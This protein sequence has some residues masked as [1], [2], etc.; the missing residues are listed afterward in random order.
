MTV[1]DLLLTR[2]DDDRPALRW[3][4]SGTIRELSWREYVGAA[5]RLA[6]CLESRLAQ[7]APPH[8]GVLLPN[9]P[10]FALH[11]AAAGLGGHVVVGLNSTAR[12]STSSSSSP[13][14]ACS[15]ASR[16]RR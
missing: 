13:T 2:S 5:L 16:S 11:L 4:E 8:V 7:G 3:R 14:H 10:A 12:G 15:N 6:E 1:R 9:G